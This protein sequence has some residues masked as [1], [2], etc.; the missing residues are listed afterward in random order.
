MR[1]RYAIALIGSLIGASVLAVGP[2]SPVAAA[3][4]SLTLNVPA[5]IGV[6]AV[7]GSA[8]PGY[9]ITPCQL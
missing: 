6:D 5:H 9:D 8:D 1:L 3:Q 7:G 2:G 4:Y